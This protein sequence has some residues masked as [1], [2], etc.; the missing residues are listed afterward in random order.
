MEID[1]LINLIAKTQIT[2]NCILNDLNGVITKITQWI[3]LIIDYG[4]KIDNNI[5][6]ADFNLDD[7][8]F[9]HEMRLA[10]LGREYK[11]WEIIPSLFHE[12]GESWSFDKLIL[13][14]NTGLVQWYCDKFNF[15]EDEYNIICIDEKI[16]ILG[17]FYH[18]MKIIM[19]NINNILSFL[20]G[21]KIY[22]LF[23]LSCIDKLLSKQDFEIKN[24]KLYKMCI[25]IK[26]HQTSQKNLTILYLNLEKA[27]D[28]SQLALFNYIKNKSFL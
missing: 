14:S 7:T 25:K 16:A 11:N 5:L 10:S 4:T 22:G 18:R 6:F 3:D 26:N 9:T 23:D 24:P 21:R 1:P 27:T 12:S 19:E 13:T 8:Y 2:I 28:L 15:T 20:S 17:V